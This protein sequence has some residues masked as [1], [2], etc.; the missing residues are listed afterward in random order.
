MQEETKKPRKSKPKKTFSAEDILRAG[1]RLFKVDRWDDDA[2][3]SDEAFQSAAD[4]GVTYVEKQIYGMA[5]EYLYDSD[6]FEKF[7]KNEKELAGGKVLLELSQNVLGGINYQVVVGQLNIEMPWAFILKGNLGEY[8]DQD[9]NASANLEIF[10]GD[11]DAITQELKRIAQRQIE[12]AI[13]DLDAQ[14]GEA[15]QTLSRLFPLD[16]E[17]EMKIVLQAFQKTK[18]GVALLPVYEKDRMNASV[19]K[20]EA[21]RGPKK[22]L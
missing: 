10:A 15:I 5:R 3:L 2:I 22:M 18:T 11:N 12:T 1:S 16:A 9:Y 14:L 19:P 6:S 17:E 7:L 13:N 8:D 4:D 21:K 20:A